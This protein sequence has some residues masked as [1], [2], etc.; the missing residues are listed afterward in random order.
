MFEP[1]LQLEPLTIPDLP[2]ETHPNKVGLQVLHRGAGLGL[3]LPCRPY[4]GVLVQWPYWIL[5]VRVG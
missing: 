5:T 2:V 1:Y 4:T 3:G